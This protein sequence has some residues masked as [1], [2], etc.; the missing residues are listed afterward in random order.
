[1]FS[2]C[3][4]TRWVFIMGD[5]NAAPRLDSTSSSSNFRL[6]MERELEN[7]LENVIRNF[8][9]IKRRC[10]IRLTSV[11][12]N[13]HP[14]PRRYCRS[15]S[16]LTPFPSPNS[17]FPRYGRRYKTILINRIGIQIYFIFFLRYLP[18]SKHSRNENNHKIVN[19]RRD[20]NRD[21]DRAVTNYS[22]ANQTVTL[23][24]LLLLSSSL[25]S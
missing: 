25:A 22:A 13:C 20:N 16:D 11:A 24:E 5:P 9:A 3:V 14:W 12:S 6:L 1:M 8:A 18:K 19:K 4:R 7:R 15:N 23:R 17:H 10:V 2:D 21:T